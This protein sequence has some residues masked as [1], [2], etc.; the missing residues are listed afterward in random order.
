MTSD[1]AEASSVVT[2]NKQPSVLR[3][4]MVNEIALFCDR[5][6]EIEFSDAARSV[7][8]DD[9]DAHFDSEGDSFDATTFTFQPPEKCAV[10]TSSGFMYTTEQKWTVALLKLL[11]DIN[12]PDHAFRLII[13][14]ARSAKN[15][16]YSF[17]PPGGLT[18]NSNVELLFKSLPNA[19]LLRPSVQPVQRVDGS[20]SEVI[21]FDFVPQ[22]LRL[23]QNP[24]VMTPENLAIDFNDPLLHYESPGNVLGEAMSG[25]VYRTAYERF[26]TNPARQLFV[27][28]IQWIDRTSVTGNDRFSLKPYMFTPAIFTESFRR[29]FQAWG[30]HGF[31]PKCKNSSAQNQGKKLGVN[32]RNYHA[33]LRVVLETFRSAN[34]RLRNITLPLGPDKSITVDIVTC[35]LF[36]IQDMQEGDMLC[37]RYGPHTPLIQRHCRSCDVSYEELDNPE[38]NCRYLL[39]RDMDRIAQ[40]DDKELQSRW[41]QHKLEN[42]FNHMPLADPERGIFGATPVETMHAYRKGIIEMV[43]F[44]VLDNVPASRKALLDDLAFKFHKSH[45]QTWRKNFPSTDFTN[46]ITNLTKISA[47]ESLG[48]VFLF[49][50][51]AQYH[52]GWIIL[53]SALRKRTETSLADIVELL[54]A[55]LCFDAWL[56]RGTFWRLEETAVAKDSAQF[57]IK[58]LM[59]MCSN[60]LPTTNSNRWNFQKFHELLHV[61]DDMSRFGAPT[62]FCA[63]R[64]ESLLIS[65]A[66][67]PGRRAQKRHHGIDYE[68]Q[69]AQRLSASGIIDTVYERI[70]NNPS[71]S[72]NANVA[73]QS[74]TSKIK[75]GTNQATSCTINLEE[76]TQPGK[77]TF[78]VCW[79]SSTKVEHLTLPIP[80][81]KFLCAKFGPKVRICTQYQRDKFTFRCHPAFQSGSAIHDWMLVKFETEAVGNQAAG[82]DNFPCKLAVV[83]LNDDSNV[84]NDDDKYRLVVQCTISRTGVKSALLTEWWWSPDY[85]IISPATICDDTVR[86]RYSRAQE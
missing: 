29:T 8:C 80:L 23:L 51:L 49:V 25:S 16:G 79:S 55:M 69:A 63:Q 32:I 36:V 5:D 52:E 66:K 9:E 50:I 81:L 39:S 71:Q 68:L 44:L 12:A 19:S 20:S 65:A 60:Y 82:V 59:S 34:D 7:P 45:R 28:I 67:Q 1:N 18:R 74:V 76:S 24:S 35:I 48:L 4:E 54:E 62:N 53:E 47:S 26:I 83:V 14:W 27:P 33:E 2:N 86:K 75:Q 21:V 42:A 10:L 30:Y 72:S 37:G 84:T 11:D 57:S 40:G 56:N 64:P 77:I 85:V 38:I 15:D 78:R 6:N 58:V 73:I 46:G 22:L 70:F 31:L 61:V 17:L 41:S 43:T 13:V 3:R